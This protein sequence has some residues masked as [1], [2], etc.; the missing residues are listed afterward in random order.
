MSAGTYV[1]YSHLALLLPLLTLVVDVSSR[2]KLVLVVG[3]IASKKCGSR[4][5]NTFP[6]SLS[7]FQSF[8]G[9]G[10]CCRSPF[11]RR[12]FSFCQQVRPTSTS[13]GCAIISPLPIDPPNP[14]IC[15]LLF[16]ECFLPARSHDLKV[17][18]SDAYEAEQANVD[19]AFRVDGA[20]SPQAVTLGEAAAVPRGQGNGGVK[21]SVAHLPKSAAVD[22]MGDAEG[23]RENLHGPGSVQDS[24]LDWQRRAG[25]SAPTPTDVPTRLPTSKP[26]SNPTQAPTFVPMKIPTKAPRKAP[27][28]RK[29]TKGMMGCMMV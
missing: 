14:Q 27:T 4:E 6:C 12:S 26:T 17:A 10:P 25:D 1:T 5:L 7:F 29:R 11:L 21:R 24:L 19:G 13:E 8:V 28:C 16:V 3:S 18:P 9:R 22:P 23:D 20:A 15:S 2:P